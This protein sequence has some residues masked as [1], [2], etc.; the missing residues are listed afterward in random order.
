[1]S[2]ERDIDLALRQWLAEE[3]PQRA[4]QDALRA[5]LTEIQAVQQRRAPGWLDLRGG[6]AAGEARARWRGLGLVALIGTAL[7]GVALGI[8]AANEILAPDATEGPTDR[9]VAS[10]SARPSGPPF[11]D[12]T[13][14]VRADDHGLELTLPRDW[15]RDPT[16]T[17]VVRVS[18]IETPG[19]MSV[20]H[21][22]GARMIL[23]DPAC[24][25]IELTAYLPVSPARTLDDVAA[26]LSR[27]TGA[28]GWRSAADISSRIANAR[29]L[30]VVV[31]DPAVRRT[32]LIG[33]YLTEIIVAVVEHPIDDGSEARV[34]RLLAGIVPFPGVPEPVGALEQLNDPGVGVA[35]SVP[36][37][38]LEDAMPADGTLSFGD[39]RLTISTADAAGRLMVCDPGCRK[40]QADD[41]ASFE[42]ATFATPG[43]GVTV[44]DIELSGSPGRYQQIDGPNG[45]P[46]FRAIA[47][48][49]GRP[50]HLWIDLSRD[51]IE[52]ALA[53]EIAR[54]LEYLR[55]DSSVRID[56]AIV[57]RGFE[58]Q[59]PAYWAGSWNARIRGGITATS[60]DADGRF[61][62]CR[63][64]GFSSSLIPCLIERATSLDELIAAVGVPGQ[65]LDIVLDGEPAALERMETYE[66]P[67]RGGQWLVYV[68]AMHHGRPYVIRLHNRQSEVFHLDEVLAG[69]H[70]TD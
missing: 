30:D 33:S 27:R 66:Y 19:R 12:G 47:L 52:T 11:S 51:A 6:P 21:G 34:D 58:L 20:Y 35:I 44:G 49:G 59:L 9:P 8:G 46:S 28:N 16:D 15:R 41:L 36:D 40:L 55:N 18:G 37:V 32:Y 63:W 39:G 14:V 13:G 56:D 61:W 23:C 31:D 50:V 1:M 7:V 24:A 70:F 10:P 68:L 54:T 65:H 60:G 69:F 38:W 25:T 57:G 42:S 53:V 26:F 67:A 62:T 2:A 43:S 29:R 4:P 5:A 64:A 45:R 17:A 48:V 3:L 22:S